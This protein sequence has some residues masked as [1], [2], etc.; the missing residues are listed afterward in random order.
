MY[1]LSHISVGGSYLGGL[2]P[3]MLITSVGLGALFVAV[4]TAANAGVPADRAGLAAA[5]MNACQQVGGAVGLAVF[6]AIATARTNHLFTLHAA[7]AHAL[8]S[9]FHRALLVESLFVLAT[10][11]VALRTTNSRGEIDSGTPEPEIV[12]AGR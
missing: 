1:Q 7:P 5:L 9:G 2:L 4:T 10:A 11:L 12:R 8:T 3:G 6:S